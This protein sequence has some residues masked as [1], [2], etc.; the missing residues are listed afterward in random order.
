M[1]ADIEMS[2]V[3]ECRYEITYL[4]TVVLVVVVSCDSGK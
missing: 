2:S 3:T 4:P 1:E